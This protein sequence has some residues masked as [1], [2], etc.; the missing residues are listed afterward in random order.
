MAN[1]ARTRLAAK[2]DKAA[3]WKLVDAVQEDADSNDIPVG[4]GETLVAIHEAVEDA[5]EDF[6]DNTVEALWRLAKFD[7]DS[8]DRQREVWRRYGWSVIHVVAGAEAEGH[9]RKSDAVRF[10]DCEQRKTQAQVKAHIRSLRVVDHKELDLNEAWHGLLGNLNA[11]FLAGA[12]LENE[13]DEAAELDAYAQAS[14]MFYLRL[15]DKQIEA[16]AAQLDAE[17]RQLADSE[18]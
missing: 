5:G 12:K 13:T 11:Y 6:T 14:R 17:W 8:T 15:I 4:S 2:A 18:A 1:F 7:A 3:R 16:E 9:W 10:L